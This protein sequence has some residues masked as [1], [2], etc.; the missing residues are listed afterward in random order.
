[1]ARL[2]GKIQELLDTAVLIHRLIPF[3]KRGYFAV[4]LNA[5]GV[6]R[7]G[8]FR[9]EEAFG[10]GL[11]KPDF[12]QD[13]R[14]LCISRR[15]LTKLQEA[16]NPVS[17]EPVLKNKGIFYR[18]CMSLGVPIPELYAIFFKRTAGWSYDGSPLI[19]PG[20]WEGFFDR[21]PQEFVV[22][23]CRGAC[24]IGVNIFSRS[25][26]DFIDADGTL[27]TSGRLY[28][29]LV[30]DPASDS[31]VIQERLRNHPER[32]RLGGCDFL[33]TVRLVT[34]ADRENRSD[35]LF[36]YLKLILGVNITDNFRRGLSGNMEVPML[37]DGRL[38]PARQMSADGCGFSTVAVHPVTGISFD[39][40]PLP[41]WE[42]TLSLVKKIS[43][44]FL[45]IRAIGW[46]V[47]ITPEGP[48]IVEANIWW[49]RGSGHKPAEELKAA[50][51]L[52]EARG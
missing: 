21:L 50:M 3:Y 44:E 13:E 37:P 34:L 15:D 32:L 5:V 52:A 16:V 49:D 27:Y 8:K 11:F 7:S 24:G 22:K 28:Q 29:T 41:F 38:K 25:G 35:I 10:M 51:R 20:D 1:M 9:P 48:R 33:Q 30:S 6:C 4:W 12:P 23:P 18:Y 47:G 19:S 31:F 17:W 36:S 2:S 43:Q 45:P 26:S 40:F 39:G 14:A 42:H 46:D